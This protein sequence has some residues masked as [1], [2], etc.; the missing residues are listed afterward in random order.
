LEIAPVPHRATRGEWRRLALGLLV[1][2]PVVLLVLVPA[3]LGLDRYVVTDRAMGGSLDRGAV[4]LARQVP[5]TDL[6][7]GD[8][9][10]F[11]R[12]D[13]DTERVTRRIVAIDD[14]LATTQADTAAEPDAW[15][16]PLTGASY[17]RVWVSVPWLGYPFVLDGGWLLLVL[18]AVVA[19]A[20]GLASGRKSPAAVVKPDRTRLPVG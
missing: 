15:V 19:L 12:P 10:T 16:V 13:G 2:T 11:P 4:V 8:V 14:G 9:I 18:A 1:L 7:V 6:H 17:D 3:V 5:P 20:L